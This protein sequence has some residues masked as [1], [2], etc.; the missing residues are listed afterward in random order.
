MVIVSGIR[1]SPSVLRCAVWVRVWVWA[2]LLCGWG[3]RFLAV[4]AAARGDGTAPR[5]YK[6]S[7][8]EAAPGGAGWHVLL[9]G[10][11]LASPQK[12]EFVLPTEALALAVA[13]EW[14]WQSPARIRPF[15]MPLMALCSTAV[16]HTPGD[17]A[18]TVSELLRFFQARGTPPRAARRAGNPATRVRR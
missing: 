11:R 2:P 4:E 12:R 3:A 8:V 13:A 10:K 5:L 6:R 14:A 9:D 18:R 1:F 17:R 15:S 7:G 16:D